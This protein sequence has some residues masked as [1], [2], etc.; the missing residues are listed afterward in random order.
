MNAAP[1]E[2]TNVFNV[3]RRK[4]TESATENNRAPER[5]TSLKLRRTDKVMAR[6]GENVW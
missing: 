5:P 1:I 4:P 2:N 6:K 3:G